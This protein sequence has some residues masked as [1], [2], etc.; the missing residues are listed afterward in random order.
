MSSASLAQWLPLDSDCYDTHFLLPLHVFPTFRRVYHI[1]L[2][3]R[4]NKCTD[5]VP[6]LTECANSSQCAPLKLH[7]DHCAERVQHQQEDENYKGP[8]EDCVEECKL[9]NRYISFPSFTLTAENSEPR[10]SG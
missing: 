5:N 8:K 7:Y 1:F 2:Y 10:F 6:L 9:C 4:V 3:V